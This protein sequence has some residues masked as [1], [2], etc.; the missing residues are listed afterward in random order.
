MDLLH[1]HSFCSM[2]IK[3][4]PSCLNL[5]ADLRSCSIHSKVAPW[6]MDLLHLHSFFSITIKL[7]PSC[8]NSLADSFYFTVRLCC[9][10]VVTLNELINSFLGVDRNCELEVPSS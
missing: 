6:L 8:L 9:S 3:L 1:L 2:T 7:A 4:A 5:L 10:L